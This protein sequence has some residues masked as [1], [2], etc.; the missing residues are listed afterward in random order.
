MSSSFRNK[1]TY[2]MSNDLGVTFSFER[3]ERFFLPS[4]M[5][6]GIFLSLPTGRESGCVCGKVKFS[7]TCDAT[8]WPREV[9]PVGSKS[10]NNTI[11]IEAEEL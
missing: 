9:S 4:D 10:K 7:P 5:I 11:S 1:Q 8:G 3:D 2:L 6:A